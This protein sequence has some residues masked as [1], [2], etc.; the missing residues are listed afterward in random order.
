MTKKSLFLV[1]ATLLVVA[2]LPLA[3]QDAAIDVNADGMYSFPE[4]QAV[5][6]EI[7]EDDFTVLDTSGDG[8][9][10]ADEIAAGT[11]AGFL[12]AMDG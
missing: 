4:L 7:T 3:A 6:P 11:E 8:L 9:L 5:M 10:D 1:P 12:P 2:A